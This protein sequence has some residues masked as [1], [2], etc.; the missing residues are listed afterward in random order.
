MVARF[1][2]PRLS[3]LI[4][5][6]ALVLMVALSSCSG[7]GGGGATS[8]ASGGSGL[9]PGVVP[10]A[11]TASLAFDGGSKVGRTHHS[12]LGGNP[13]SPTNTG[14][15][16]NP[17][18]G[19]VGRVSNVLVGGRYAIVSVISNKDIASLLADPTNT[20]LLQPTTPQASPQT[21]PQT[22]PATP[23]QTSP[24]T[25]PQTSP[26]TPPLIFDFNRLKISASVGQNKQRSREFSP[27]LNSPA[28][29]VVDVLGQTINL[30]YDDPNDPTQ[31]PK[32]MRVYIDNRADVA[33]GHTLVGG[34]DFQLTAIGEIAPSRLPQGE[35]T[36][37]Y[38]G[39]IVVASP[40]APNP[41]RPNSGG[42]T[43][44]VDFGKGLVTSF[45]TPRG[46]E[47]NDRVTMQAIGDGTTGDNK[48]FEATEIVIDPSTGSFAGEINFTNDYLTPSPST[49]SSPPR[50]PLPGSIIKF[51]SRGSIY[52]QFHGDHARGVTGVFH[53]TPTPPSTNSPSSTPSP[54]PTIL[55]G[56]A[57]AKTS[58]PN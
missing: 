49:P 3:P 7:G 28:G 25:P 18:S 2:I 11:V 52:G 47:D 45:N 27:N 23:P 42:F 51:N 35:S 26:A 36:M 53:S 30:L 15:Q 14:T 34:E 55:G 6:L 22:S 12:L 48:K 33:L 39:Y 8:S 46:F 54:T 29:G 31:N 50:M 17:A 9:M 38:T 56:F 57:G 24:A 4:Q 19:G 32:T 16:N 43:M 10:Q 44:E 13:T 5:Y 40:A 20:E 21:P 41:P 1:P 37:T 58:P